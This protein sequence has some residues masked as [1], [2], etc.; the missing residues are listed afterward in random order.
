[1]SYGWLTE[2]TLPREKS[3]KIKIDGSSMIG[4]EAVLAADK[5]KLKKNEHPQH[6]VTKEHKIVARNPGI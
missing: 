4:I 3:K 1:M 6:R 5:L 2:S